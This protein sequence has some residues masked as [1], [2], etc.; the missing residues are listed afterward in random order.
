MDDD[1]DIASDHPAVLME[2][3]L[4]AVM[5]QSSASDF[6]RAVQVS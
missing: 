5:G 6:R 4:R 3:K 1:S 2:A